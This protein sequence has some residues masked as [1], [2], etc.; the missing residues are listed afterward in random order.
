MNS[1]E[2][3]Q[4]AEVPSLRLGLVIQRYGEEVNGGAEYHCRLVAEH[5]ARR[6]VFGKDVGRRAGERPS[7]VDVQDKSE[8]SFQTYV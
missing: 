7:P 5:L 4:K 8:Q 2:Q 3:N 1:H 6:H